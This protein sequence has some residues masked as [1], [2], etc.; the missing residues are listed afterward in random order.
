M[1]QTA[2][3]INGP[4]RS[5][6]GPCLLFCTKVLRVSPHLAGILLLSDVTME[7]AVTLVLL[8]PRDLKARGISLSRSQLN[9][10]ISRGFFPKPI[11]IGLRRNA[12]LEPEINAWVADRSAARGVSTSSVYPVALKKV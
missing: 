2:T 7:S 1:L 4:L 6:I 5:K 12:W 3:G 10:L 11:K 8:S 9:E